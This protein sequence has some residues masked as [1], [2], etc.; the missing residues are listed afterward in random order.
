MSFYIYRNHTV[1]PLFA[2]I[3]DVTFSG[4]DDISE[5]PEDANTVLWF[6]SY[7][8]DCASRLV[9]ERIEYYGQQLRMMVDAIPETSALCLCTM[10][11][12][13]LTV[14]EDSDFSIR[15]AVENYNAGLVE[16]ADTHAHIKVLDVASFLEQFPAE[17]RTDWKYYYMSQ[18]QVNPALA[19][20][21]REWFDARMRAIQSKRK[22]CLVLDLDNTVWGGVLGE[23]GKDGIKLSNNYP[24][25]CYRDFQKLVREAIDQ[26]VIVAVCSKNNEPEVWD[27]FETHPDM[28]LKKDDLSSYRINWT[29][30]AT[31]LREIAAELNIGTDSLVFIDDSPQER[32]LISMTMPEVTVPDYPAKPYQLRQFMLSVFDEHFR[33]YQLTN[34]DR[35]KTS[36]YKDNARRVSAGKDFASLE[37]F[38]RTLDIHVLLSS[39]DSYNIPRIAQMTQK[40][41]QFNLTTKRYTESDIQKFVDSGAW[42]V[43]ASVRDKFGDSGI[44]MAAVIEMDGQRANV[45]SFLLSCRILGRKIELAIAQRVFNELFDRGCRHIS[46]RYIPTAKN[47]Q[48][49]SF[50]ENFGFEAAPGPDGGKEYQ[51]EMQE[52]FQIADYYTMELNPGERRYQEHNV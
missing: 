18:M 12:Q 32:A 16:L 43:C 21:F 7:P 27:C 48:T 41:N 50:F 46:A 31:N 6:Y 14:R 5:V 47:M 23:D 1:E 19:G 15:G 28:V 22:K 17:S 44:T 25:S 49:E 51:L 45:D 39:A 9:V 40:T 8:F 24:G 11:V 34:E 36:Q 42:V 33:I 52:K 38:I 4:Y 35:K 30:K 37:D 10:G 2:R 26:G 29:D 13:E 20:E 3:P